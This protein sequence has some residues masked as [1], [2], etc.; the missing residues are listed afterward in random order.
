MHQECALWFFYDFRFWIWWGEVDRFETE[1]VIWNL[2]VDLEDL[3]FFLLKCWCC[4]VSVVDFVFWIFKIT[5]SCFC[6]RKEAICDSQM[7][8]CFS[9][10]ANVYSARV[11]GIGGEIDK[12]ILTTPLKKKWIQL[13]CHVY[14]CQTRCLRWRKSSRRLVK[15]KI[16][17]LIWWIS[18]YPPLKNV[19]AYVSCYFWNL[20][21]F[22]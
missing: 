8:V 5:P 12:I 17:R 15:F 11:F 13:Q 4:G 1:E 18:I 6:A 9:V 16:G 14:Q 3:L 10:S 7:L 21:H 20:F 19:P 22:W 2:W